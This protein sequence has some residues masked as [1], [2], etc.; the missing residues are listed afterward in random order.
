VTPRSTVPTGVLTLAGEALRRQREA[1]GRCVELLSGK[2][3]QLIHLPVLEYAHGEPGPGYR[4]VDRAGHLVA[5]RTDFTPLAAR[6]LAPSLEGGPLPLAVCYAGEVVRPRPAR[7][8]QL[9]ELYQ[10][11]F[12]RYGVTGE[13]TQVLSLTLRLL[14]AAGVVPANCHVT[15]SL[16]GMAEEMLAQLLEQPADEELLELLR[17]RDLDALGEAAALRGQALAALEAAL[18]GEGPERWVDFFGLRQELGRLAP[19]LAEAH[20]AGASGGLDVAPRL[21]GSYYRGVVFSV[22]GRRTRAV[23]A[24]VGEYEVALRDGP[25]AAAGA[26]LAL[27]VALEESSCSR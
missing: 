21:A 2:G 22:W 16:A 9:P 11:G 27:G 12:E 23:L 7:L 13:G 3:F 4:F 18:L 14:E 19:L 10:L 6:V 15:V 5:L 17:V 20:R 25:L 8:R 24:A 26:C 1:E